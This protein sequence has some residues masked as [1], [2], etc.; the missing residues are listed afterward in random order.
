MMIE[1]NTVLELI[2]EDGIERSKWR[3]KVLKLIFVF[4]AILAI[5]SLLLLNTVTGIFVLVA[6][7]GLAI[8]SI[9]LSSQ[10]KSLRAYAEEQL[11]LLKII[12]S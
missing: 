12:N 1:S 3:E 6:S 7:V 8:F 11:K 10:E 4:S 9:R 2:L 5:C